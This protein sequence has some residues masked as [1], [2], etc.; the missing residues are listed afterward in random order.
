MSC[1]RLLALTVALAGLAAGRPP[2]VPFV[3]HPIDNG[4]SETASVF[5]VN[6]DG[7]L[8]IVTSVNRGTFAFWGQ[9]P[10]TAPRKTAAR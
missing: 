1:P 10:K 9:G 4:A 5:D 8:D 2:N 6:G 7:R 3:V